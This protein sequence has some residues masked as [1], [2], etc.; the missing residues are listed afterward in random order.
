[1]RA[2]PRNVWTKPQTGC[3]QPPDLGDQQMRILMIIAL[4]AILA[5]CN[6]DRVK[7]TESPGPAPAHFSV[8]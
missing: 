5:G 4:S 1:M 6:G 8:V 3:F 7:Q 2:V